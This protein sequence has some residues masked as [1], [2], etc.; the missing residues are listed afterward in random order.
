[1][2]N[3]SNP[4]EPPTHSP[5]APPQPYPYGGPAPVWPAAPGYLAPPPSRT[6]KWLVPVIVIFSVTVLLC[7][8]G[9]G[10]LIYRVSQASTVDTPRRGSL[11]VPA[12][13]ATPLPETTETIPAGP[14]AATYP[15]REDEDLARVCDQWYYPTAPKYAGK[16]PHQI[17]VGMVNDRAGGSRLVSPYVVDVPYSLATSVQNAWQAEKPAKS[18]LMACVDLTS[19]GGKVKTC[20]Y[21]DPKPETLT[22]RRGTYQLRVFEVATGRKVMEK[23]LAGE[24][25]ECP[26]FVLVQEDKTIYSAPDG[27]QLYELLRSYVVKKL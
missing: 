13:S 19:V 16:G 27:R 21:T 11:P 5:Y 10:V 7:V 15:V 4:N 26:S 3:T 20:K 24:N 14:R 12:P 17:S 23:K 8:G 18:Q 9:A 2:E 22:M 25:E 6:P 1:M